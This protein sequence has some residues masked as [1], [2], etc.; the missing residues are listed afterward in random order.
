[1]I[2]RNEGHGHVWPRPDGVRARC[3]GPGICDVCSKD[4]ALAANLEDY[5]PSDEAHTIVYYEGWT[6]R[7]IS[8]KDLA[9]IL[10]VTGHELVEYGNDSKHGPDARFI[11]IRKKP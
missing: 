11:T 6:N 7:G 8:M 9:M 1:M 4:Q 3:G 10:H 5:R 2:S